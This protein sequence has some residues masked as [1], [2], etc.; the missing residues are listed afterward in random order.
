MTDHDFQQRSLRSLDDT[1]N[2]AVRGLMHVDPRPG[3]RRRV[4]STLDAPVRQRTGLPWMPW[5]LA[6]AGALAALLLAVAL[7]DNPTPTP[8]P[9]TTAITPGLTAPSVA[10][11][12]RPAETTARTPGTA[13]QP[14][15][16]APLTTTTGIFGQRSDRV[17]AASVRVRPSEERSPELSETAS[18]PETAQGE[19]RGP[20][21]LVIPA[22]DIQPLQ[23]PALS[24]LSPR[25]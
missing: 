4:L 24:A 17:S 14:P 23:L 5:L 7:L 6:P 18:A 3:L 25:R 9:V 1:I 11:V 15:R 10:V 21:A 19:P 12:P 2:D 13:E 20:S 16:R 22:L 8:S